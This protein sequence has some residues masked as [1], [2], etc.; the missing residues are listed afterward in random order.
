[1][2]GDHIN[3]KIINSILI[4]LILFFFVSFLGAASAANDIS[5]NDTELSTSGGGSLSVPMSDSADDTSLGASNDNEVLSAT[6][7]LSGS[8]VQDIQTLFN[9][10]QIHAGDTL[11]LGNQDISSGWSEWNPNEIINVNVPNIIIS[12]GSSSNPNGIS[13]INANHAKVFNI[14]ASGVTLKNIR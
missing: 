10:G 12:G 13:T 7:D 8:T 11:Y 6:Y 2:G 3:K 4:I 14:Q 9:N 1:M 5:I